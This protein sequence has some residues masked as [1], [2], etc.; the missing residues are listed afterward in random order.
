MTRR[1]TVSLLLMAAISGCA[2]Q[3][4]PSFS[5]SENQAREA[6]REMRKS[7]R[8]LERPLV[9]LGGFADVGVASYLFK[10]KIVDMFDQPDILLVRFAD[11]TSFEECRQRVIQRVDEQFGKTDNDKTIEVDVV[12]QSMGGLIAILSSADFGDG[13][14]RL[15]AKRIFALSS[16]LSGAKLAENA[17]MVMTDM[18]RDMLPNS[19]LYQRLST[20]RI[21]A[22]L[23]CYT[24]LDD[25]IVGE[26][27]SVLKGRQVWWVDNPLLGLSHLQGITDDRIV[28]D[29]TRR[30]RGESAYATSPPAPLPNQTK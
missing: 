29:V 17:P 22:Q 27:F 13:Q 10:D 16:P 19:Q 9:I 7:P 14:R 25:P 8:R 2:R 30:L 28:A 1:L 24:R 6:I 11:C 15:N 5:I 21:D 20:A 3:I 26:Y 4:N 23:Y 12:G 18:H